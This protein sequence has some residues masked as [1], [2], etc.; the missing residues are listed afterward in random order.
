[1]LTIAKGWSEATINDA[2]RIASLVT[3][4]WVIVSESDV[5]GEEFITLVASGHL[6]HSA[7]HA[8]VPA[9]VRIW[10]ETAA[11]TSR[12]TSTAHYLATKP[13]PTSGPRTSSSNRTDAGC[14]PSPN[15]PPPNYPRNHRQLKLAVLLIP[16][17]GERPKRTFRNHP[18]SARVRRV[19]PGAL[20]QWSAP[21]S[22]L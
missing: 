5:P 11:L 19:R 10:G 16:G 1:M 17:E 20:P 13:T 18:Y 9:R 15:T 4:D 8:A 3:D 12:I 7:V 6:T 2:A 22:V 21:R 14:V